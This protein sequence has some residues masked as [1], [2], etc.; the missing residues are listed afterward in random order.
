MR[1]RAPGID[2]TGS[3]AFRCASPSRTPF[4][5][6][7]HASDMRRSPAAGRN[8]RAVASSSSPSFVRLDHRAL[9]AARARSFATGAAAAP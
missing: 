4:R 9:A 3:D 2:K 8:G 6:R 5:E 1:A 7:T